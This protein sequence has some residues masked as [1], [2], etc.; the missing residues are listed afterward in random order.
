MKRRYERIKIAS[1]KLAE[2]AFKSYAG[3]KDYKRA[4]ELYTMLST[5]ICIPQDISNFSKN[6]MS[7]LSKKIEDNI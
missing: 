2:E 3:K 1:K 6:M 5:Y 7:K 4:I